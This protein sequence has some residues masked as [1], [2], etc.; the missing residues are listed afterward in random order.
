MADEDKQFDATP[1]KLKKAKEEGQVVKSRDISTAISIIVLFLLLYYMLPLVWSE[2]YRLFVAV[3]EQIPYKSVEEIGEVYLVGLVASVMLILVGPLLA[4]S[5]LVGIATEFL[6]VGPIFA[7]KA[8]EP[9]FDKLN[10][11]KGLKNLITTRSLFELLKNILKIAILGTVGY[12]VFLDHLDQLLSAGQSDNVL[13]M[14][15]ILGKML[16]DFVVKA[17]IFFLFIGLGDYIFQRLKF[18]KDQKMSFKEL[19]DE[20]KNTEGDPHVKAALRQRRMQMMQQSMMRNIP[21]AD[22]VVTN[23]IHLAVAIQYDRATMEAPRVIA[24]G[25]E[26]F[27]QRIKDIAQENNIPVV[28]NVAVA[29]ALYRTVEIDRE[30]PPELYEVVAEILMFAWRLRPPRTQSIPRP[31]AT[32]APTLLEE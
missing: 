14:V 10:P 27:A 6:Q 18:M 12:Y 19:K 1:Y 2:I 8:I 5:V 26:L 16:I 28:E 23:P 21:Q 30:I 15:V 24:K 20:F 4:A 7:T 11:V 9:K 3:F 22:V 32:T 17:T 25:A 31:L 29:Q 13:V